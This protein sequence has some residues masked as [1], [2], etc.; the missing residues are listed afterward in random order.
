MRRC[1]SY[2]GSAARVQSLKDLYSISV[3]SDSVGK[4]APLSASIILQ[5]VSLL[6]DASF[7]SGL[8]LGKKS[9]APLGNALLQVGSLDPSS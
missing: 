2:E 5:G 3:A 7:S 1:T 8:F 9:R 6:E 4:A